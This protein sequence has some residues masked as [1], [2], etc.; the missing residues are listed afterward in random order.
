[1]LFIPV[2]ILKVLHEYKLIHDSEIG[3]YLYISFYK[4]RVRWQLLEGPTSY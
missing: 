1:M 2:L 4:G 3:S